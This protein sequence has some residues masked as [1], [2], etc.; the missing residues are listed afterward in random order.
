MS[1]L[2][3]AARALPHVIITVLML[4]AMT[5][6]L[7]GVFLRYV[8]TW[9]SARFDLPTIG[10]QTITNVAEAGLGGLAVVAGAAIVV[11]PQRIAA[12]AQ[13]EQLFVIGIREDGSSI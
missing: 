9:V 6:M 13:R 7:V 10:P 12:A 8:M 2:L 5:D 1:P 11:E 3:R 4:V